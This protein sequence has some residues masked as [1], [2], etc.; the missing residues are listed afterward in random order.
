MKIIFETEYEKY[1]LEKLLDNIWQSTELDKSR[2]DAD[3]ADLLASLFVQVATAE[4]RVEGD[5]A[6]APL[7]SETGVFIEQTTALTT[8]SGSQ[9]LDRLL[10]KKE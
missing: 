5:N 10:N 7:K 6:S 9:F 1:K 3:I 2:F 8:S 4:T